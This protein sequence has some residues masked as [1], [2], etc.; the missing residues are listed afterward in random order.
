MSE[1][2]QSYSSQ[3]AVGNTDNVMGVLA[4]SLP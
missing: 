3:R 2:D 4:Q 1:A